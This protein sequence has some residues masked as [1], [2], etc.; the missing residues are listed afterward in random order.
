MKLQHLRSKAAAIFLSVSLL[1]TEGALFA[2]TSAPQAS[3]VPIPARFG[4]VEESYFPEKVSADTP[5]IIYIQDAHDSLEAQLNIANII[6]YFTARYGIKTVFEEGYEGKVPT[7]DYF[8]F[9]Q[10]P[11]VKKKLSY[12]LLDHLQISGAEYEHINRKNF[13][14][15]GAENLRLY[16]KNIEAYRRAAEHQASIQ[17]D[18]VWME[19]EIYA[20]ARQH[21]P[22]SLIHWLQAKELFEQGSLGLAEYLK[23]LQSEGADMEAYPQLY[24]LI[25]EKR[26]K[27]EVF[28][29]KDFFSDLEKLEKEHLQ[30]LLRTE[31]TRT[32]FDYLEGFSALKRLNAIEIGSK[33]Y[34]EAK[35]FLKNFSTRNFAEFVFK[36]T[37]KPVM[38]SKKWEGLIAEA[39]R[40]YEISRARDHVVSDRLEAFFKASGE[41]KAVLVFG[42]FHKAELTRQFREKGIAYLVLSPRIKA[43]PEKHQNLYRQ[44]MVQGTERPALSKLIATATRQ[45]G[46]YAVAAIDPSMATASHAELR[47]L[48]Q[49]LAPVIH[50]ATAVDKKPAGPH[51]SETRAIKGFAGKIHDAVSTKYEKIKKIITLVIPGNGMQQRVTAAAMMTVFFLFFDFLITIPFIKLG[52]VS[53]ALWSQNPLLITAAIA[54]TFFVGGIVRLLFYPIFKVIWPDLLALNKKGLVFNFIPWGLGNF[55]PILLVSSQTHPRHLV[56]AKEIYDIEKLLSYSVAHYSGG[57]PQQKQTILQHS[58]EIAKAIHDFQKQLEYNYKRFKIR[59]IKGYENG[60]IIALISRVD[61]SDRFP[62]SVR[63]KQWV[64]K[65]LGMDFPGYEEGTRPILLI[66]LRRQFEDLK[67]ILSQQWQTPTERQTHLSRVYQL[68]IGRLADEINRSGAI[69]PDFIRPVFTEREIQSP[70]VIRSEL[71]NELQWGGDAKFFD[72]RLTRIQTLLFDS[73]EYRET[74]EF[75]G[76]ILRILSEIEKRLRFAPQD[77]WQQPDFSSVREKHQ[78]WILSIVR[79]TYNPVIFSSVTALAKELAIPSEEIKELLE[80]RKEKHFFR[81]AWASFVQNTRAVGS[82]TVP[83]KIVLYSLFSVLGLG[84][85]ALIAVAAVFLDLPLKI[86]ITFLGLAGMVIFLYAAI[87]KSHWQAYQRNFKSWNERVDLVLESLPSSLSRS[88]IRNLRFEKHPEQLKIELHGTPRDLHQWISG[89]NRIFSSPNK[90]EAVR[91]FFNGGLKDV[92]GKSKTLLFQDGEAVWAVIR[93][94]GGGISFEIF[95]EQFPAERQTQLWQRMNNLFAE[96]MRRMRENGTAQAGRTPNRGHGSRNGSSIEEPSAAVQ[97]N[98]NG[99]RISENAEKALTALLQIQTK[100]KDWLSPEV[101]ITQKPATRDEIAVQRISNETERQLKLAIGK[102]GPV[103]EKLKQ[104]GRQVPDTSLTR[105]DLINQLKQITFPSHMENGRSDP[106]AESLALQRQRDEVIEWLETANGSGTISSKNGARSELRATQEGRTVTDLRNIEL[107]QWMTASRRMTYDLE[108]A[109]QRTV[110]QGYLSGGLWIFSAFVLGLLADMVAQKYFH[111][112]NVGSKLA[113]FLIVGGFLAGALKIAFTLRKETTLKE[114]Y[115]SR[116]GEIDSKI[117]FFWRL[118]FLRY[119]NKTQPYIQPDF[120]IEDEKIPYQLWINTALLERTFDLASEKMPSLE[121]RKTRLVE[122]VKKVDRLFTRYDTSSHWPFAEKEK[123]Y[124]ESRRR[125]VWA[126][127]DLFLDMAEFIEQHENPA[128]VHPRLGLAAAVLSG[129]IEEFIKTGKVQTFIDEKEQ[130][131]DSLFGDNVPQDA[132]VSAEN[133]SEIRQADK[134]RQ[135]DWAKITARSLPGKPLSKERAEYF[136]IQYSEYAK[137]TGKSFDDNNFKNLDFPKSRV[138]VTKLKQDRLT[139]VFIPYSPEAAASPRRRQSELALFF[140]NGRLV[141]HGHATHDLKGETFVG[142]GIHEEEQGNIPSSEIYTRFL[143][144]VYAKFKPDFFGVEA[145]QIW[146]G[147][148]LGKNEVRTFFYLKRG[149]YLP[150]FASEKLQAFADEIYLRLRKGERLSKEEATRVYSRLVR[151]LERGGE[152]AVWYSPRLKNDRSE[153]RSLPFIDDHIKPAVLNGTLAD[154]VL[155]AYQESAEKAE[156]DHPSRYPLLP[157]LFEFLEFLPLDVIPSMKEGNHIAR[158]LKHKYPEVEIAFYTW[159]GQVHEE[160]IKKSLSKNNILKFVDLKGGLVSWQEIAAFFGVEVS[161]V[162]KAVA[163]SLSTRHRDT[164]KINRAVNAL[165][166]KRRSQADRDEDILI[167]LIVEQD[168]LDKLKMIIE[169]M[170]SHDGLSTPLEVFENLGNTAKH[171]SAGNLFGHEDPGQFLKDLNH[172]RRIR[173]RLYGYR[174]PL[175]GLVKDRRTLTTVRETIQVLEREELAGLP[176]LKDVLFFLPGVNAAQPVRERMKRIEEWRELINYNRTLAGRASVPAL[177]PQLTGEAQRKTLKIIEELGGVATLQDLVYHSGLTIASLSEQVKGISFDAVNQRRRH[178][179]QFPLQVINRAYDRIAGL[180]VWQRVQHH[181]KTKGSMEAEI[182][183]QSQN[184]RRALS[185]SEW[186]AFQHRILPVFFHYF[187]T[188]APHQRN[189]RI[190]LFMELFLKYLPEGKARKQ[191]LQVFA[192]RALNMTKVSGEYGIPKYFEQALKD[193]LTEKYPLVESKY[194]PAPETSVRRKT[195]RSELRPVPVE[196][197][198]APS[199]GRGMPRAELRPAPWRDTLEPQPKEGLRAELRTQ[200]EGTDLRKTSG[201]YPEIVRKDWPILPGAQRHMSYLNRNPGEWIWLRRHA[202]PQMIERAQKEGRRSLRV[203]VLGAST[204]EELARSFHE[205]AEALQEKGFPLAQ[206]A[207]EPQGW[208]I[209]VD[210]VEK[211]NETAREAYLRIKGMK[212]FVWSVPYDPKDW[213]H[214]DPDKNWQYAQKIMATLRQHPRMAQGNLRVYERNIQDEEFFADPKFSHYDL[215]LFNNIFHLIPKT[216]REDIGQFIHQQWPG[217][218]L[219]TTTSLLDQEFLGRK[220]IVKQDAANHVDFPHIYTFWSPRSELRP[221]RWLNTAPSLGRGVHRAEL[222]KE[223]SFLFETPVV[224]SIPAAELEELAASGAEEAKQLWEEL[225][226]LKLRNKKNLHLVLEAGEEDLPGDAALALMSGFPNVHWGWS[227]RF[228]KMPVIQFQDLSSE[229]G[230]IGRVRKETLA[231]FGIFPGTFVAA[232]ALL[233]DLGR[234]QAVDKKQLVIRQANA[235][236]QDLVNQFFNT[237]VVV[238]RSA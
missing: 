134:A 99:D 233:E 216:E 82:F 151:E 58:V 217:A 129:Q 191:Y 8:G 50:Q 12:F 77:V 124:R 204:G 224:Y 220:K 167:P 131:V 25:N 37:G 31:Q 13:N 192:L 59:G 93:N 21:F 215:V 64:L 70:S 144:Y 119:T 162:K 36:L 20:L 154:E 15:I 103:V 98:G 208:T 205:M 181:A 135:A 174:F 201:D 63:L 39:D 200:T 46:L 230:K 89:L 54:A 57:Q 94:S 18:L 133:R 108:A 60:K 11:E 213:F 137:N 24:F 141:G 158:W 121:P 9:V 111:S 17:E 165:R 6:R 73:K 88:E 173:N 78:L 157:T 234:W 159:D 177:A 188:M 97:G 194:V 61:L 2:Q 235:F 136:F 145:R 1:M 127:E 189:L 125:L 81:F 169:V 91:A 222:R 85:S 10:N 30:K 113:R 148:Y 153:L 28:H 104:L 14:L 132:D 203:L 55:S 79:G 22:K 231:V 152:H 195:S 160:T 120:Q 229:D 218:W 52:I 107:K 209:Y 75:Y 71:R 43:F 214:I 232:W 110:Q 80:S 76:K 65:R 3:G 86:R 95:A 49:A 96:V 112:P 66:G 183:V 163:D 238:A 166:I 126:L 90:A 27:P 74:P 41:N 83:Q 128:Y 182:Y 106:Y 196:L 146:N 175:L 206:N 7:Q 185:R 149:Y 62:V 29:A 186:G 45:A 180:R 53:A 143:R 100:L 147:N 184:L 109:E 122:A 40:F 179:D 118:V 105:H 170:E 101:L 68:G 176:T 130:F 223:H 138:S 69:P 51:R 212:P 198:T 123:E 236:I 35:V 228:S 190:Q 48:A 44:L 237:F 87:A 32:I 72:Q 193:V 4:T 67:K 168:R 197:S 140:I 16:F 84:M 211:N 164:R 225:I 210:G 5:T 178:Y 155:T 115:E 116:E 92:H 42:G 221:A 33:D 47:G 102:I 226:G 117:K 199:L 207:S 38:F 150:W 19:K 156:I 23:K 26:P 142:F 187:E 139:M 227:P 202:I 219:A 171:L 34:A 114:T 161:A 56:E 172:N